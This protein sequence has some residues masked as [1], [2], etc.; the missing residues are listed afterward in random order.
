MPVIS[1]KHFLPVCQIS[2]QPHVFGVCVY[3]D[4]TR[5]LSQGYDRRVTMLNNPLQNG[6]TLYQGCDSK[7]FELIVLTGYRWRVL[8]YADVGRST[9]VS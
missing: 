6:N 8:W 5:T 7:L 2:A 1:R 9:S 4:T 3:L